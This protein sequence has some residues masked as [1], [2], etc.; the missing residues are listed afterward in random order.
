MPEPIASGRESRAEPTPGSSTGTTA[1]ATQK[2]PLQE[3][4][5]QSKQLLSHSLKIPSLQPTSE[6]LTN[7][8]SSWATLNG[9]SLGYNHTSKIPMGIS[10]M[11]TPFPAITQ[12]PQPRSLCTLKPQSVPLQGARTRQHHQ[13]WRGWRLHV[14]AQPAAATAGGRVNG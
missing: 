9:I 10:P 6:M 8:P 13:W 12:R 7:C 5:C 2:D 1:T 3:Q 4:L 14:S 11:A